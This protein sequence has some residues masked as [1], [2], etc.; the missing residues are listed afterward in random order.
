MGIWASQMDAGKLQLPDPFEQPAVAWMETWKQ[1][2][3]MR[4]MGFATNISLEVRKKQIAQYVQD[5]EE[6]LDRFD[7]NRIEGT[8]RLRAQSMEFLWT[9]VAPYKNY[10]ANL[11]RADEELDEEK[12]DENAP[13][14]PG[15]DDAPSFSDGDH[16]DGFDDDHGGDDQD[17]DNFLL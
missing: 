10:P 13:L 15:D 12:E 3:R 4:S 9:L 7:Q 17:D 14:L 6:R 5:I 2:H 11:H 1:F 8:S 16:L